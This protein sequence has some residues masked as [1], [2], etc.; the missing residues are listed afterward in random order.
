LEKQF[1]RRV[2]AAAWLSVG[3]VEF[4]DGVSYD[5]WHRGFLL[6]IDKNYNVD[7]N[8]SYN[9]TLFSAASGT[10]HKTTNIWDICYHSGL[11]ELVVGL[12]TNCD[13]CCF[14]GNNYAEG[15]IWRLDPSDGQPSTTGSTNPSL[16]GP[17]NAFDLRVGVTETSDGGFAAISSRRNINFTA[18][19]GTS[20]GTYSTCPE[21]ATQAYNVPTNI[22]DGNTFGTWDTDPLIVQFNANG[23]KRWEWSEDIIVGRPRTLPP[24]G[25]FKR[26]ECMYKITEA[27]DG[28]L[29]ASG[30]CSY[31]HDDDYLVKLFSDC[32]VNHSYD[33][34]NGAVISNGQT[35]IWNFSLDIKGKVVVRSGG[36]LTITGT[37]TKIRFADSRHCGV[38][39][40]IEI[41]PGGRLD[42]IGGAEL[43][44]IDDDCPSSMWDGI[45]LMG[46]STMNQGYSSGFF[47]D[48]GLLVMN[49]G[50]ISNARTSVTTGTHFPLASGQLQAAF[51]WTTSGGVIKA[52]NATFL[53]NNRDVQFLA[54]QA[55][56]TQPNQSEFIGC[57]F[58]IN[59]E[60]NDRSYP[61]GRVSMDVVDGVKFKGCQ[62]EYNADGAYLPENRG[63]GVGS[64]DAIYKVEDCPG[65][66][67]TRTNFK[68][69]RRGI[70]VFNNYTTRAIEVDHAV[71]TNTYTGAAG[72][73]E[74]IL[75]TNSNYAKISRCDFDLLDP[76]SEGVFIYNSKYY[77]IRNNTFLGNGDGFGIVVSSSGGGSH[78][79]YRNDFDSHYRGIKTQ[80]INSNYVG[81]TSINTIFTPD[82]LDNGLI[83]NC[84][85]F[86]GSNAMNIAVT[87]YNLTGFNP[88]IGKHQG[89][90]SNPIGTTDPLKL[91]RNR[92]LANCSLGTGN[93]DMFHIMSGTSK[94]ILH[95]A[96]S[97]AN[98]RPPQPGCANGLVYIGN[99]QVSFNYSQH[100]EQNGTMPISNVSCPCSNCCFLADIGIGLS[101][102]LS[103]KQ[104][105]QADY[106][107]LID[108]GDSQLLLDEIA[109]ATLSAGAL[110]GL[111]FGYSPYLSDTVLKMFILSEA[112]V[113][114]VI[115]VHNL[116][117]PVSPPVWEIIINQR[118]ESSD[119]ETL[120][121]HQDDDTISA[122]DTLESKLSFAMSE[123]QYMFSQKVGYHIRDTLEG[124]KDTVI[125]LLAQNIGELPDAPVQLVEAYGSGNYYERAFEVCD[126]LGHIAKYE[127]AMLLLNVLLQLDTAQT[128]WFKILEDNNLLSVIEDFAD[129]SS[130]AGC[131]QARAVL[132]KVTGKDV[133]LLRVPE[134]DSESR[135]HGSHN[136]GNTRLNNLKNSDI[137]TDGV[138]EIFPNPAKD[139][140]NLVFLSENAISM[141]FI[142][143]DILGKTIHSGN[144]ISGIRNEISSM[145]F[146]NGMYFVS[147]LKDSAVVDKK[148]IVIM[149]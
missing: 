68:N 135:A 132:Q 15:E 92:Y 108:G 106:L 18:P 124:S 45:A 8:W 9:P 34:T 59:K 33:F 138:L 104:N 109:T 149:K 83:M 46:Q 93:D 100:C 148:K 16:M 19:T 6:A 127:H 137:L 103:A 91:V 13:R 39:T 58:L 136:E 5:D 12:V 105:A 76:Q 96:N 115:S 40:Y 64:C 41:E 24:A 112:A 60:L 53:N 123:L 84:N 74:G 110:R 142:I 79:I 97:D 27:W 130:S 122:R 145:N 65:C 98:T 66:S 10:Y 38:P 77:D 75:I 94:V 90:P 63:Y 23:T 52:T 54:Y 20:F 25:D 7:A 4:V 42:V 111:L 72:P 87:G 67:V 118:Y 56:N 82:L 141:R 69:F 119:I 86:T 61:T 95:P 147:L 146:N 48:Q 89:I 30:N 133:N 101:A 102:A 21:F 62:F 107:S 3:S 47:P 14:S 73:T 140:F 134:E 26:Q 85:T 116:N 43:T 88:A 36:Y 44:S 121:D 37:G 125:A 114:D 31:N 28:G 2:P 17:I 32:G 126:S 11:N 35:P 113:S 70:E 99:S 143:Q 57:R 71:F 139:G 128:R 80:F 50:T 1:A 129:D 78:K 131:Y 144:L 51:N 120:E 49:T 55:P 117:K 22:P 81:Y 29:V